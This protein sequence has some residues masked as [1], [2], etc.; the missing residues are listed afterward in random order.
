MFTKFRACYRDPRKDK[1]N[2]II[3]LMY[4][5]VRTHAHAYSLTMKIPDSLF[6]PQRSRALVSRE[7]RKERNFISR[8]KLVKLFP[9]DATNASTFHPRIVAEV[10]A[11][12]AGT[13]AQF[14]GLQ[15]PQVRKKIQETGS[16]RGYFILLSSSMIKWRTYLLY[17]QSS[18]GTH[19]S[20][21]VF[22]FAR[23]YSCRQP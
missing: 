5:Q 22:Y 3:E 2:S 21:T 19:T 13:F 23:S 11:M 15:A 18:N 10:D 14:F 7:I 8:S 20:A 4:P 12:Y 16:K 6:P 9:L 1:R 17:A